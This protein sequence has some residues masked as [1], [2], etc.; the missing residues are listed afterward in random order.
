MIFWALF[1]NSNAR[2]AINK[3]RTSPG[4]W[5][6]EL[7]SHIKI[8][9]IR[10]WRPK[11]RQFK[12]VVSLA[13][14]HHTA[15]RFST[16]SYTAVRNHSVNVSSSTQVP[17]QLAAGASHSNCSSHAHAPHAT[18]NLFSI[19]QLF[20]GTHSRMTYNHSRIVNH[21]AML[22]R[23]TTNHINLPQQKTFTYHSPLPFLNLHSR[24]YFLTTSR[25]RPPRSGFF[26]VGESLNIINSNSNYINAFCE[27]LYCSLYLGNRLSCS[28]EYFKQR[29]WQRQSTRK[30]TVFCLNS[31]THMATHDL[32]RRYE[33]RL[34]IF[35]RY[36]RWWA[37]Q[38]SQS[39]WISPALAPA[40][41]MSVEK[42]N[43]NE[44]CERLFQW[45]TELWRAR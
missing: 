11:W 34:Y 17:P 35:V 29:K 25:W 8:N 39:C 43:I 24:N 31:A 9:E 26:P 2:H 20:Y 13:G 1:R 10:Q 36:A 22:S 23:T 27:R 41:K 18:E 32:H 4:S 14:S 42:R 33:F 5:S 37:C 6:Q 21:F 28:A 15:S 40:R 38:D 45:S 12:K 30:V 19:D 3:R 7:S 16:S 44:H